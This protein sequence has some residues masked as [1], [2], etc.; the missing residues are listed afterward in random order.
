M[1]YTFESVEEE[2]TD[3]KTPV[4]MYGTLACADELQ[5]T[6][7]DG[8]VTLALRRFMSKFI[9]NSVRMCGTLL[10]ISQGLVAGC[11]RRTKL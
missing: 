10:M 8:R 3:E 7:I 1:D 9:G 2:T 5:G 6:A 11:R 4:G